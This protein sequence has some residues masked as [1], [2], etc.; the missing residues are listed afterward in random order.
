MSDWHHATP[1]PCSDLFKLTMWIKRLL[2][3]LPVTF[4]LDLPLSLTLAKEKGDIIVLSCSGMMS[5]QHKAPNTYSHFIWSNS[6]QFHDRKGQ[7]D[8]LLITKQS[9][10]C[11]RS[12]DLKCSLTEFL[13]HL[14]FNL[15]F[16][17]IFNFIYFGHFSPPHLNDANIHSGGAKLQRIA[18]PQRAHLTLMETKS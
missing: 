17:H 3:L 6:T 16:E 8:K 5:L 7:C 9:S 2:W 1:A 12:S 13:F 4:D 18:T 14:V 11:K 10:Y 15:A